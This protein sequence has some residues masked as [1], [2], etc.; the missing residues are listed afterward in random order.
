MYAVIQTGG[1]QYRVSKGDKITVEKLLA[2]VGKSIT[3]KDVLLVND[4]KKLT[5]GKP[6]VK[7]ASV[8][9]KV[10]DQGK[11]DKIVVFKKKRRKGYKRKQGHRQLNTRIEIAEIS[12]KA[13]A[14]KAEPAE[15][16]TEKKAAAAEKKSPKKT[17]AKDSDT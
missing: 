12:L 9:A 8:K 16:K 1:K 4:G 3:I 11:D 15:E 5:V 7:G 2:D 10:L 17:K 13:A 6:L 14:K